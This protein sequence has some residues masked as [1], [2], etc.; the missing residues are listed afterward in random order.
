MLPLP[1]A[2][3]AI[4][5]TTPLSWFPPRYVVPNRLPLPSISRSVIASGSVPLF[6]VPAFEDP[7]TGVLLSAENVSTSGV[8]GR[9]RAWYRGFYREFYRSC[10]GVGLPEMWACR[11]GF[12]AS[13]YF[14]RSAVS[15]TRL[16]Q[17][18]PCTEY[19][20][21]GGLAATLASEFYSGVFGW[22]LVWLD[23]VVKAEWLGR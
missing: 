21:Q 3:W 9:L 4:S 17:T 6:C 13:A 18:A 23:F 10:G 19:A 5:K 12:V 2:V 22:E 1:A 11:S 14:A 20:A 7:P 15:A 16:S 8:I